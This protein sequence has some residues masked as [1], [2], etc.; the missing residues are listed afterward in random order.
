MKI[1]FRTH[2]CIIYPYFKCT[3]CMLIVEPTL[4]FSFST[5][6]WLMRTD[7]SIKVEAPNQKPKLIQRVGRLASLKSSML[8]FNIVKLGSDI[9][10]ARVSSQ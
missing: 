1:S 6:L 10:F 8:R 2:V 3:T 5:S 4:L 9:G 7:A